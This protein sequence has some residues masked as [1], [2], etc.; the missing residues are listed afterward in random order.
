MVFPWNQLFESRDERGR[1][2]E[3]WIGKKRYCTSY[4]VIS[5]SFCNIFF[6]VLGL[7]IDE[8]R[9]KKLHKVPEHYLKS[10]NHIFS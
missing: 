8:W 7:E 2:S 5:E 9:T 10:V 3:L 4:K 1:K 6:C